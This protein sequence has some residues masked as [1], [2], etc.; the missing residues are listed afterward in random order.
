MFGAI[1][2]RLLAWNTAVLAA[3]LVALG[4]SIYFITA[5]TLYGEVNR[6]LRENAQETLQRLSATP[7][8]PFVLPRTGYSGDVFYLGID[9]TGRLMENP[10][11]L[12]LTA[13]PDP[14]GVRKALAG[15]ETFSTILLNG[16]HVRLLSAPIFTSRGDL[17]GAL[18]VGR[19]IEPERSALSR[20]A[21]ILALSEAAAL[22]LALG[23]GW[24]L[25][26]RALVPIRNA[27]DRQRRFVADASH[28][29]RTPLTLIRSSSELLAR[30]GSQTIDEN[31]HLVE[32]IV[33]ETEYLSGMIAGLLTLAQS[34]AGRLALRQESMALDVLVRSVCDDVGPLARSNGLEL[35]CTTD[36]GNGTVKGDRERLRQLLLLLLDNAFKYTPRQG[37]VEVSLTAN[38][39]YARLAITDTGQGI[40]PEHLEHIFDRFYRA[41][42]TRG[43]EAGGSGL[44][45]A[46]AKVLVEAHGGGI[47]LESAVG[48]GTTVRVSLPLEEGRRP[49]SDG[50]GD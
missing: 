11:G 40:H 19:S 20:L 41:D 48:E 26:E 35:V 33:S 3:L 49:S 13:S 17:L 34:D 25:A 18:Q 39:G 31:R 6:T 44:G 42:L 28:E 7:G 9:L 15:G 50:D 12:S 16:Q 47:A 27:F 22:A 8:F 30:H 4:V 38:G 46:I 36:G 45:L 14:E 5:S 2:R 21:L 37:R 1:R 10:Q 43:R 23:G 32:S 29:L 24:F